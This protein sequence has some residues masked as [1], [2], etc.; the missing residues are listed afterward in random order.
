MR[1]RGCDFSSGRGKALWAVAKIALATSV[2]GVVGLSGPS[3]SYIGPAYLKIPGISGGGKIPS[4]K[5]WT[6]TESHYW[7][8]PGAGRRGG[9]GR[10]PIAASGVIKFTG[11]SAPAKG[12]GSLALAVD[13]AGP[14][15][16]QLMTL[17]AKGQTI[18]QVT[19]A[20]N[21][22]LVRPTFEHGPAP[23]DVPGHYEYVLKNV[24]MSCPVAADAPEQAVLLN[25][26]DIQ[27]TNYHSDSFTRD[28]KVEP[29]RLGPGPS[30]GATRT[31]V[32]TWMSNAVDAN[33]KQCAKMNSKPE[34]EDYYR[35]LSPQRAAEQRAALAKQGGV[36]AGQMANRGPGE[37]N[38]TKL[39]G[40]IR[41][42]GH[43]LPVAD[44]VPGLN[45]DGDDGAG[46][47]PRGIRK[48]ANFAA[49]WGE[50]GVDNQMFLVEGCV[51]GWRRNGFLPLIANDMRASGEL[52]I[53]VSVSGIDDERND[54]EVIVDF[55]YSRD[56]MKRVGPEKV[57]LSDYTYRISD[58]MD[59]AADFVR[60]RGRI[61]N[62]VV[63]TEPLDK[64][65]VH[66]SNGTAQALYR[67]RIRVEF[68]PDGS[69]KG[70]LGGYRDWREY[71]A[72][73]YLNGSAYENTIGYNSAGMYHA[74]R[75][76][77]D[78]LYDPVTGDYN[79]IS[80]A[81]EMEGVSAFIPPEQQE[82]LTAGRVGALA[83]AKP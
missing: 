51:E 50:K 7:A 52:S 83:S 60:F 10:S 12:A 20:E 6:R 46:K 25:F 32:V 2:A 29:A 39:P 23:A 78:G 82:M 80:S 61:V 65:Y 56:G 36:Q 37:L 33:P 19:F 73:A 49:P 27:W 22:Q 70:Y 31:A 41:D 68:K 30:K 18:P 54:D 77:A 45:L 38:A 64:M 35:Y 69:M 5:G 48:H 53:L 43:I 4:Y 24:T 44:V 14:G 13:K 55:L 9:R 81:F 72:Y 47:A 8:I 57:L 59:D 58:A 79:G 26:E 34:Q 21:S 11:P 76:A 42:S 1:N 40:I 74:I 71:I 28:L 15:L 62:G 16:K 3:A 63:V 17:C 67:P 75:K 66:Y